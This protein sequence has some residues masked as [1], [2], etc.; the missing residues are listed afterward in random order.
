MQSI[1]PIATA[2]AAVGLAASASAQLITWNPVLPSIGPGDVSLNGTLVVARNLHAATAT[3]SPTVNGVTFLGSL[4]P[5]GWGVAITNDGLNGSTTGDP[6]YDDLLRQAR[7][8]SA[9]AA[10]PSGWGAIQLD[11]L[12]TLTIGHTYEI[13]CWYTDQ[14]TGTATNVLYDRQ[15]TLSSVVDNNVLLSNGEVTNLGSLVKGPDS[16]LLDADPDDAPAINSPDVLF[17]SYCIG[18]FTRTS[19]DAMWLLVQGS[20]PLLHNLKPHLT[21]FQIR[22]VGGPTWAPF[23]AG[24]AGPAGTKALQLV[25]LPAIGGSFALDVTNAGPGFVFMVSGLTQL[26]VPL[27]IAPFATGCTALASPDLTQFV[28]TVGSTASWVLGIPNNPVFAG[29]QIFNQALE[30]DALW[31]LSNG[32]VGTLQ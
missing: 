5:N 24:C 8:T 19:N 27:P 13:Q 6:G 30:L 3:V 1:R 29:L 32:G 23:G 9:A 12:G 22:D 15:M 10:S 4:S 28:P 16:G 14:R 25:S 26:N 20:H 11:T 2:L 7:A 21:A 17:G 31:S 18:T